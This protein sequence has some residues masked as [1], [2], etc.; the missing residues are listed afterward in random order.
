MVR[1]FGRAVELIILAQVRTAYDIRR[2]SDETAHQV[3]YV[4][5]GTMI[6]ALP[7]EKRDGLQAAYGE[8]GERGSERHQAF[9]GV[10]RMTPP[11]DYHPRY[12]LAHGMGAFLGETEEDRMIVI[13]PQMAW[14]A[15]LTEYLYCE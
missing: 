8:F 15:V 1:G 9:C 10:Q 6:G 7:Q 11:P 13:N 3:T 4:N 14:D 12:M 2:V 5:L